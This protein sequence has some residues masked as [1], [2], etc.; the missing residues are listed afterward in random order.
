MWYRVPLFQRLAQSKNIEFVF[1]R[2]QAADVYRE[3]SDL[4]I[5]GMEHISYRIL[6]PGRHAINWNVCKLAHSEQYTT[7]ELPSI[8][9]RE[10]YIE[11]LISAI[12]AKRKGA[13]VVLFTEY[14][15]AFAH[16]ALAA[17][18]LGIYHS[19][20]AARR[21]MAEK[22]LQIRILKHFVDGFI[23]PG[24]NARNYLLGCGVQCNKIYTAPD[25]S[26]VALPPDYQPASLG[27][28]RV[29]FFGRL[30]PCKGVIV[31]LKALV[32]LKQ[33]NLNPDVLICGDG[34]LKKDLEEFAHNHAL[35]SVHFAGAISQDDRAE[36][37]S[38]AGIFVLP[39]VE[40]EAWGLSVNEAMQF[41]QAVILTQAT[42][43][44]PDLVREGKNGFIVP[45]GN[46]EALADA[47]EMLLKDEE[48]RIHAQNLSRVIIRNY[49]YDK[50]SKG[51]LKAFDACERRRK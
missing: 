45:A 50:M 25:A 10:E 19:A 4:K 15:E 9:S 36:Y 47:L 31:V 23:V 43:C 49:T 17:G 38:H 16:Q 44:A 34:E 11:A 14:W 39:N 2:I 21:I 27:S 7:L 3:V 22:R 24:T 29:L 33:R 37:Y 41:G 46:A 28:K 18:D 42:G 5:T 48:K 1:T 8:D 51:F 20:F 30:V 6:P 32:L 12:C 40:S 26:E 13:H 35:Y